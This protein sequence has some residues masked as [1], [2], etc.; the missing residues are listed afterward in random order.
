LCSLRG[1]YRLAKQVPIRDTARA[2]SFVG[3][4][5]IVASQDWSRDVDEVFSRQRPWIQSHLKKISRVRDT[6]LAHI[7][8][9]A[10]SG[11][12]PSIVAF[13]DLLRFAFDFHLFVNEAFLD[14]HPHPIMNDRHVEQSLLRLLEKIGVSYPVSGFE[15][16]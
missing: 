13:E 14:T 10:P 12:L 7:Q 11:V 15:D 5:D 16:R 8:Q 6:R 4:Y 9:D 3:K 2:R 1:V